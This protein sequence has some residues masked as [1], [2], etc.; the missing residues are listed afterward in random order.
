M[1]SD[2]F[3]T[4]DSFGLGDFDPDAYSFVAGWLH[5]APPAP[6]YTLKPMRVRGEIP[7]TYDGN[8][9][10]LTVSGTT[11]SATAI[12]YTASLTPDRGDELPSGFSG[13][14]GSVTI[15]AGATGSVIFEWDTSGHAW[16]EATPPH[17]M[18]F[19]ARSR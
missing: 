10:R 11:N 3:A 13:A 2:T 8:R 4:A 7:F 1:Q 15:A 5:F 9:A 17:P 18:T 16:I 12:S 6:R 19:C 14:S